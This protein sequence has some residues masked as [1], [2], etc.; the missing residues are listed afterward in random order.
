MPKTLS[1]RGKR[2]YQ[3]AR[4]RLDRAL[5]NEDWHAIFAHSFVQYL[6]MIGPDHKPIMA[7]IENKLSRGKNRSVL[8][9]DG[10]VGKV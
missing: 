5:A 9:K 1:W 8:T 3:V 7:T 2:K 4:C 6:G 10:L